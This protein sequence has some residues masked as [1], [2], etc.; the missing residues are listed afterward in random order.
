MGILTT[1]D[2]RTLFCPRQCMCFLC[3]KPAQ[4]KCLLSMS[5]CHIRVHDMCFKPTET[6]RMA[7]CMSPTSVIT[8][9]SC[10]QACNIFILNSNTYNVMGVWKAHTQM[11]P[12]HFSACRQ[13]HFPAIPQESLITANSMTTIPE[14]AKVTA[15]SFFTEDSTISGKSQIE[16]E[17]TITGHMTLLQK[18]TPHQQSTKPAGL[19]C[20]ITMADS[21]EC[22]PTAG[23][24]SHPN[25]VEREASVCLARLSCMV[26]I[27]EA[28]A[29]EWSKLLQ[30]QRIDKRNKTKLNIIANRSLPL[31][32]QHGS[33]YTPPGQHE[34]N[35][36]RTTWAG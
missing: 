15:E 16:H 36:T 13:V 3:K 17:G 32:S 30:Q 33:P 8:C 9:P 4:G 24:A 28:Q 31:T 20:D 18:S 5:C 26:N 35:V 27:S 10:G 19:E 2:K 29:T 21:A 34:G 22:P 11:H 25:L 6:H 12:Q 23:E 14:E 1:T 7:T